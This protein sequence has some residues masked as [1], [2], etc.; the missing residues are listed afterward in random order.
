MSPPPG[1][2]QLSPGEFEALLQRLAQQRLEPND[3][4]LLIRL[5]QAMGWMSHELEDKKLSIRRLQ[6]IFGIK[7]E[8]SRNLLGDDDEEDDSP[9]K[10]GNPGGSAGKKKKRKNRKRRG[11]GRNGA[12]AYSGA[13]RIP[14][15]L[16]SVRPGD[17]CP[18]CPKG[19]LYELSDPGVVIRVIGQPPLK[20]TVYELQKYRCNLCGLVLT[21]KLPEGVSNKK[22]DEAAAAMLAMIRYGGGLPHYR[23]RRFQDNLGIP[24]PESTQWDIIENA[25]DT[26]QYIYKELIRQAAQ[27]DLLHNDDT[28]M[29]I[30]SRMKETETNERKGV[31]TTGVLSVKDCQDIAL[32]F[33]GNRHA[34]ENTGELL[35]SR[36]PTSDPPIQM[37]D[38]LSRN[39]PKDFKVVLTNCMAH[40]R[41]HFVDLIHIFPEKCTHVIK[42]IGK[43]YRIDK[44]AKDQN[45]S[46]RD[47]LRYHQQHSKPIMVDLKQWMEKQFDER[48]VEPNSSL[49]K[50][51]KY[52]LN[53]WEPL[54][55]FLE[56]PGCPL[57]NNIV[58]RCLKSAI[59]HRKN[60]L[61][62][63]TDLGAHVG[64]IFMSII[65]TCKLAGINAFD[66][67]TEILK[68]SR[69]VFKNPECWM[70][71]NYQTAMAQS[72]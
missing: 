41:R 31:F 16:E 62:Y 14:V 44:I 38:A 50:A 49:G 55:R 72:N 27:G 10:S 60:S 39:I 12:S 47:R 13:E 58:E 1:N 66:Y 19:R 61:F 5:V 8:S 52:M 53:H 30:L 2:I 67:L 6:R 63:K 20:A 21:A 69:S 36:D 35:R 64:D 46:H 68:N 26:A 48:N 18:E 17:S 28:T 57:D 71:W 23:L 25:A 3:Y 11:H 42:A 37:C 34:G 29:R 65:Q 32:Y 4:E 59:M 7:T 45:M 24:L 51:F 56:I 43:V 40:A 33:T 70:P 15:E 54:T 22:Y 9:D